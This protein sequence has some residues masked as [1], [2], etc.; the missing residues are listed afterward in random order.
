MTAPWRTGRTLA[1]EASGSLAGVALDENGRL[2]GEASVDT[3]CAR[4]E[5]LLE[6]TRRLLEDLG[7]A[8][9]DLD[10]VACSEGPGSF[11]GLRVAMA[12]AF[13]LAAG[14][15]VPVVPV[16]SLEVLAYPWRWSDEPIVV[17]SGHRRGQV[18]T[19]AY[20]WTGERFC[21]L[22]TP[23]SQRETVILEQAAMLAGSRL[24]FVGDA[25]DSLAGP[26]RSRF[27]ERAV[28]HSGGP[29]RAA[30]VARLATDPARSEWAGRMLEGRT[31]CYLRDADARKAKR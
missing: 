24:L 11:T 13:G 25:L 9:T 1:I 20:R 31:P 28:L 18:Y 2:L 16:S 19:A 21:P 15:G 10:R 17:L 29:A 12:S 23:S 30:D 3:R 7:L 5:L 26:I 6:M 27:G 8:P 14:A 4:A 22:I